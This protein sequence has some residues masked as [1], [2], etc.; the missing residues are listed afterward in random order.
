MSRVGTYVGRLDILE[1]VGD[2]ALEYFEAVE[3]EKLTNGELYRLARSLT[4]VGEV[5]VQAGDLTAAMPRL[6]EALAL[7]T[8]LVAKEP[9]NE[10][11]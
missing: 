7:A 2:K 10:L 6:E 4:Q 1:D 3:E 11:W 5:D 9:E 8:A